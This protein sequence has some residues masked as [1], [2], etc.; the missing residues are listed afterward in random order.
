MAPQLV[1]NSQ[2]SSQLKTSQTNESRKEDTE[3]S[4]DNP[5]NAHGKVWQ[6]AKGIKFIQMKT[7]GAKGKGRSSPSTQ[8]SGKANYASAADSGFRY[9]RDLMARLADSQRESESSSVR[10]QPP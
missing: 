6:T 7:S 2:F 10:R 8:R 3:S 9:K 4:S 1:L 5:A